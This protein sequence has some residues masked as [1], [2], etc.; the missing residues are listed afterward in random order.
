MQRLTRMA[1]VLL[2]VLL[3]DC[4]HTDP[5][6]STPAKP[7]APLTGETR[8]LYAWQGDYPM[9][10]LDRLPAGQRETG[11]GFIGNPDTFRRVWQV[12]KPDKAMP[13]VDFTENL[14][15]FARNTQFYNRTNI[16]KVM[17][18]NGVAEVLAVETLS[19]IPIEDKVAM[20]LA[21]VPRAGITGVQ[22]GLAVVPVK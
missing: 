5:A 9:A 4:G 13:D 15:L 20:A 17:V 21:V 3:V 8:I 18:K 12:F 14:V 7:L 19:A 10:R 2:L 16:V 11:T 1:T 22:T 6:V